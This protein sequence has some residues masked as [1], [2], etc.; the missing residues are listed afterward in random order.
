MLPFLQVSTIDLLA[1]AGGSH[2]NCEGLAGRPGWL[3]PLLD[4]SRNKIDDLIGDFR[5]Q[6]LSA[7]ARLAEDGAS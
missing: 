7:C 1:F 2:S 5:M 4:C 6:V 3:M